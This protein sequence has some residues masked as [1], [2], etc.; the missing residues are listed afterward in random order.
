MFQGELEG[1]RAICDTK[2]I[3]APHPIATGHLDNGQYFIVM[4]YLNMT[5]LNAKSSSELGSRLADM[6]MFNLHEGHPTVKQFGFHIE[7]CCGFIPQNN[8]WTND[9]LV[10]K[11][12]YLD[13]LKKKLFYNI[14][15]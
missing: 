9:W 3:M 6:H 11:F 12:I 7:T 13:C 14:L 10:Y 1:L 15:K 8:T 5:S 4:E 2:T